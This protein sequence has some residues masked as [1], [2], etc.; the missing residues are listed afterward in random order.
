MA[1]SR[2]T[3][4]ALADSLKKQLRSK[5]FSCISI[6]DICTSCGI[7][8]KSFY[9]HFHDKYELVYWIFHTEWEAFHSVPAWKNV[10]Q[11]CEYLYENREFYRKVLCVEDQN[12]LGEYLH[13]W[14]RAALAKTE[15]DFSATFYAD[16]FLCAVKRWLCTRP[17]MP[18]QA[19]ASQLY[20]CIKYGRCSV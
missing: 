19:F 13:G 2:K 10:A 1:D 11:L 12:C 14:C 5:P 16:A 6:A 18:P 9:Y 7:R 17:T 15:D 8:R 20:T 4:Q 3:K